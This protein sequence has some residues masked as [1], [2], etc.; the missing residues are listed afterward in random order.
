MSRSPLS[1]SERRRSKRLLVQDSFSLF[2]VIPKAL[3][4]VKIYLRDVSKLG[5]CFRTELEGDFKKDTV[6][7]LRIYLSPLFYL[8]VRARVVR[9]VGG[10][11][12][13]EFHDSKTTKAI[14]H[15]IDFFD[16]AADAGLSEK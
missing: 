2:L 1:G 3:G 9:V 15:L 12:A 8:P 7:D 16:A 6:L 14:G 13:V 10:E 5:L 11:V 4:M